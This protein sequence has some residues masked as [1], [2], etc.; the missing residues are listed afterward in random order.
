MHTCFGALHDTHNSAELYEVER[1]SE[2]GDD[3]SNSDQSASGQWLSHISFPV[4][5]DGNDSMTFVITAAV[6]GDQVLN[7]CDQTVL[8]NTLTLSTIPSPLTMPLYLAYCPDKANNFAARMKV[9]TEH[10]QG[11]AAGKKDGTIRE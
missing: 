5:G 6:V 2:T 9:R 1:S 4:T 10:V 3:G 11:S 8:R 7:T